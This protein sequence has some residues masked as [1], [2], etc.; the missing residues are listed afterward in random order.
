MD[1]ERIRAGWAGLAEAVEQELIGW[2][3]AH[4]TATLAEIEAEVQAALSRLQARYPGD[5]VQASAAANLRATPPA[6][7]PRCPGCGGSLQ[8]V[9]GL[10]ERGI[11]TPGQTEP[12]RLERGYGACP[13]CGVGL[14]PPGR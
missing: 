13:A 1:G 10:Q 7:R 12:L 14:F 5:L 4:P 6:A 3:E 2:R 11:L 8:P 9:G